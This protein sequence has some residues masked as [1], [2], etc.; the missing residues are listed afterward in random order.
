MRS[1][2]FTLIEIMVVVVL[3][4]L[5]A[6]AAALT[7][8]GQVAE[9]TRDDIVGQLS[10]QDHMARLAARRLGE[11]KL[12]Y[13][14]ESQRIW[15]VTTMRDGGFDRS[16]A[17][18]LPR[19]H[20]VDRILIAD[21]ESTNSEDHETGQVEIVYSPGGH[22]LSYALR[23]HSQKE[24]SRVWLFFAGLTGQ[25]TVMEDEGKV[26]NLLQALSKGR[27]DVD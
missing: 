20:A 15:R 13:D 9:R 16:H 14:L 27:P 12:Q 1:R 19:N 18:R 4:G 10:R 2:A 24:E 23:M 5:L 25:V 17:M 7:L 21:H 22:S 6:G 11:T 8:T 3:M 26:Y